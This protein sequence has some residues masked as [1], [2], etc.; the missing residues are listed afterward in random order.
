[1]RTTDGP[2]LAISCELCCNPKAHLVTKNLT[3]KMEIPSPTFQKSHWRANRQSLRSLCHS[4]SKWMGI[5]KFKDYYYL[6]SWAQ[7]KSSPPK[8]HGRSHWSCAIYVST[9]QLYSKGPI[10]VFN[11]NQRGTHQLLMNFCFH[12]NICLTNL[13][14]I[15]HEL[16]NLFDNF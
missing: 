10:W 14:K 7:Y 5:S 12:G 3:V 15:S 6:F 11:L 8:D 2:E 9:V 16:L 1:M 4:K 13:K